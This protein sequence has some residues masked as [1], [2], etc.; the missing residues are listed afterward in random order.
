ALPDEVKNNIDVVLVSVG[1][2][3]AFFSTI[4]AAC[5]LPS[6]CTARGAFFFQQIDQLL[7]RLV[8]GYITVARRFPAAEVVVVPY[9]Q[10]LDPERSCDL[11]IS[12]DERRFV[13]QFQ[14]RLHGA[15][16]AAADAA[17]PRVTA[18]PGSFGALNQEGNQRMLCDF[19]EEG[20]NFIHLLPHEGTAFQRLNPNNWKDGSL[21]PR[22]EGHEAIADLLVPWLQL[23]LSREPVVVEE[24]PEPA[25]EVQPLVLPVDPERDAALERERAWVVEQLFVTARRTTPPLAGLFVGGMLV[26]LGVVQL[27]P[28]FGLRVS[29]LKRW[30]KHEIEPTSGP[31]DGGSGTEAAPEP[32][33]VLD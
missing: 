2:N 8:D 25:P 30:R 14:V 32:E 1:G 27:F 4:V 13:H 31:P 7:P 5:L 12:A 18:F 29:P 6:D 28:R 24:S 3:D 10:L 19:G 21:H 22:A 15:L 16:I 20:V 9:P 33:P 26:A 11:A 23:H 17:G